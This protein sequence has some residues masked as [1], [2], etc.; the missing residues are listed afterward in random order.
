MTRV[1]LAMLCVTAC[2]TFEPNVGEQ[3]EAQCSDA[4][5]D[6]AKR[7]SYASDLRPILEA[8]CFF[9]HSPQGKNPIGVEVGGLD[10]SRYESMRAGGVVSGTRIIVPGSPCSSLLVEKIEEYP[11]FGGRMPL[12]G[13]PFLSDEEIQL[14]ADWIAEGAREK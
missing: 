10:L 11:S 12:S 4:D 14:F 7:V 9:C 6:G 2:S 3:L 13:P 5:S 8:R 1:L